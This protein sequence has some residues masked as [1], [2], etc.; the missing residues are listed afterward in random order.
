MAGKMIAPSGAHPGRSIT[1]ERLKNSDVFGNLPEQD[2]L[3]IAEFCTEQTYR[4]GM[5]V[6]TEGEVADK[7]Y[8]VERGKLSLEKKVVVGR[9]SSA[10]TATVGYVGPGKTAGVS[11]LTI[12]DVYSTSAVCVEPARVIC[13][14]G[15]ALRAYLQA[16]P[17]TGL[18]VMTTLSAMISERYRN[19]ANTLT[20]FLSIVAHELR[21]PLA[22]IENYLQTLLGGFAGELTPKQVHMIQ[23]CALRLIDMQALIGDVVDLARMRP[24]QI[25]DDFEWFDPGEVGA[26]SV[27]DVRLAAVEKEVQ[28]KI[29][30]PPQFFPIVGSRRRMRQVF[31]NL[32]NNAIK[33]SPP[34]SVVT[35][36]AWYEPETLV[37]EVEDQGPGIP[38]EDLPNLF[39]DFYRASNVEGTPGSGLGLS[40]AKKIMDAHDGQILVQNLSDETG[41]T[42]TRFTVRIPR[43]LKTP[44]MRRREWQM[45]E[46]ERQV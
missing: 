38:E 28:I 3:A 4:E 10:R 35:F 43:N 24:E 18:L 37:F 36:R 1:V 6:L 23:R 46:L 16:H 34:G 7:L 15:Q 39:K 44:D 42:G 12:P 17:E 45:E 40:I 31:T 25:Q 2:L 20:Y 26:E 8:I 5:V 41:A 22:A 13:V 32:L 19:A 21:S 30:P 29:D 33:F 11:T 27:E 14:D 9:Q